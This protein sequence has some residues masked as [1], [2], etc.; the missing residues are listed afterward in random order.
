MYINIT[1]SMHFFI[2]LYTIVHSPYCVYIV[3]LFDIKNDKWLYGM[4][5]MN[6]HICK[7]DK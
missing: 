1:G 2:F 5:E 3:S 4:Y 7:E 6:F